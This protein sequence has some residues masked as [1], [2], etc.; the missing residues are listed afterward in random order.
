MRRILFAALLATSA[1]FASATPTPKEQLL[2]PPKDARHFTI[3]SPATKSGDIWSWKMA[4]GSTAYRMSL[5]LRGWIT[6]T[7]E[8]ITPG[9]DGRPAKI[10]IRG[11]TDSGEATENFSVD[12]S[13]IAHWKTS[14]DEG[15]APYAGKRYNTYGGP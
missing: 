5:N 9:T 15:S 8:V 7:D 12:P 2:V 10:A 14:V 3:S 11:Y 4:D 1:S 13:G 6:E